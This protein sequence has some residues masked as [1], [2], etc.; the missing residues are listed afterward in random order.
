MKNDGESMK[1]KKRRRKKKTLPAPSSPSSFL[2]LLCFVAQMSFF[3]EVRRGNVSG[4]ASLISGGADVNGQDLFGRTALHYA[5]VLDSSEMLELLLAKGAT[6]NGQDSNGNT[7][8]HRAVKEHSAKC[9][10][11]LLAKA[12][13]LHLHLHLTNED[14]FIP[15]DLA[16]SLAATNQK[17]LTSDNALQVVALFTQYS[18]SPDKQKDKEKEHKGQAPF[19]LHTSHFTL[20]TSHFTLHTHTHTHTHTPWIHHGRSFIYS[21]TFFFLL[22]FASLSSVQVHITST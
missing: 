7:P 21:W 14:G 6:A 11:V 12:A 3:E 8:L 16:T 9:V 15:L 20:H 4:V 1:K 5:A 2:L 19:T 17:T 10:E 18:T 13:S 22:F